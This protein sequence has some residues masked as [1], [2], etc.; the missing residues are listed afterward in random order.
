MINDP[1]GQIF[2]IFDF[3]T[4]LME[5]PRGI[6]LASHLS[7]YR[8]QRSSQTIGN[9]TSGYDGSDHSP[10]HDLNYYHCAALPS[11]TREVAHKPI[12]IFRND[13]GTT[14]NFQG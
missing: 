11:T 4:G 5:L 2:D 9:V 7:R 8:V 10:S 6:I 13:C 1:L 3:S 14:T 12:E